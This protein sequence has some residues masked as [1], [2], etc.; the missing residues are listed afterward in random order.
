MGTGW[1]TRKES[2]VME[3]DFKKGLFAY[4]LD[5]YYASRQSLIELGVPI[6]S[7]VKVAFPES[8]PKKYATPP[9][10]WNG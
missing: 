7:N 3:V 5:I 4:S 1:G 2:K 9:S 6:Q 8:F 10:G